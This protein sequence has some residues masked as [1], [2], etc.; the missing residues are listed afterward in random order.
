[1]FRGKH[2]DIYSP[3]MFTG[4]FNTWDNDVKRLHNKRRGEGGRGGERRGGER[5][6][7]EGR[8]DEGRGGEGE[9]LQAHVSF[10]VK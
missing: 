4:G 2:S 8:G 9:L 1:M 5:R 10:A 7:G 6:G 3:V